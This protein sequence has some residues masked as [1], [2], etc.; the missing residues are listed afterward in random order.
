MS[1]HFSPQSSAACSSLT[2]L[3]LPVFGL[4]ADLIRLEKRAWGERR[5]IVQVFGTVSSFEAW[6]VHLLRY[7]CHFVLTGGQSAIFH[8]LPT[9]VLL[10]RHV[11]L[12]VVRRERIVRR[13]PSEL[14]P[15][16]RY[17]LEEV[18][19]GIVLPRLQKGQNHNILQ[20]TREHE[21]YGYARLSLVMNWYCYLSREL[22]IVQL[23]QWRDQTHQWRGD[24]FSTGCCT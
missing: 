11:R 19:V 1:L 12:L 10:Q 3:F 18:A 23:M 24:S 20:E 13:C 6:I 21:I 5:T 4:L 14:F 16:I 22:S 9:S 8:R 2:R 15:E 7:G 17:K